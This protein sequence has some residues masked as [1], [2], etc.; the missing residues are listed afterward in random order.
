LF[1]EGYD[2][3]NFV[4]GA[5]LGFEATQTESHACVFV[6]LEQLGD[7]GVIRKSGPERWTDEA[8]DRTRGEFVEPFRNAEFELLHDRGIDYEGDVLKLAVEDEIIDKSGAHFS[9]KEQRLGQG[10]KNAVEFLRENPDVAREIEN[11]VREFMGIPL[12]AA[13]AAA[14]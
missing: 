6:N 3:I 7:G 2:A 4:F 9:F 11:K 1:D 8:D 14:A 12:L 10:A 13:D 5:H